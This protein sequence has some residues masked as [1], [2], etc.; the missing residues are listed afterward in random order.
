MKS[1]EELQTLLDEIIKYRR[2]IYLLRHDMKVSLSK[3]DNREWLSDMY[4]ESSRTLDKVNETLKTI[5]DEMKT[6]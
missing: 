1:K 5:R 4:L 6:L 2:N 3:G